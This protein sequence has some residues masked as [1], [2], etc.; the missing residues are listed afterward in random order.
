MTV[1]TLY[2]NFTDSASPPNVVFVVGAAQVHQ[3]LDADPASY[4]NMS[5]V[6]TFVVSMANTTV[7]TIDQLASLTL[8]FDVRVMSGF[9]QAPA[10][11][12]FGELRDL[13]NG[14]VYARSIWN[15]DG[16]TGFR[17]AAVKFGSVV[18]KGV[19]DRLA[20]YVFQPGGTYGERWEINDA[21]MIVDSLFDGPVATPTGPTGAINDNT[22]TLTWTTVVDDPS[23]EEEVYAR[24]RVFNVAQ[25]GAGAF[26]PATSPATWDSGARLAVPFHSITTV[27]L[28]AG[29]YRAYVSAIQRVQPGA[30]WDGRPSA[31][32]NERAPLQQGPYAFTSFSVIPVPPAVNPPTIPTDVVRDL[33]DDQRALL[34]QAT[35]P[36]PRASLY[37]PD[38]VFVR[39]LTIIEKST[40]KVTLDAQS[41][42]RGTL[43]LVV[44]DVDIVPSS[45]REATGENMPLHPF[46][47]YVHISYG[48][49]VSR[50]QPDIQVGVGVFRLTSVKRDLNAG[51]VTIK[52]KDF[53]QNLLESR[54]AYPE[55]RQDWDALPPTPFL[56]TQTVR[57]I[58][59]EAGLAYRVP[60]DDATRVVVNYAHKIGDER[61]RALDG[62]AGSLDGWTWYADIDGAIFFGPG[63]DIINDDLSYT[64]ETG[65]PDAGRFVAQVS[66]REQELTRDD[67]FDVVVAYDQAVTVVGGA[68]DANPDSVIAR[69]DADPAQ[70]TVGAGPF[71]P[72]GKPFFYS[73]PVI[74]T[75]PAAET[76]AQTRLRGVAL[77]AEAIAASCV[78][79]PDL[80]PDKMVSMARDGET[81]LVKWQVTKIV[82]P[83]TIGPT[84]TWEGVALPEDVVPAS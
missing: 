77:P 27:P 68:Y 10:D 76:A 6:G 80:R 32:L 7:M 31:V 36:V 52:G 48:I 57:L 79:I 12:I 38:G 67:V 18:P 83:L 81:A 41:Q 72:G 62:L 33:T 49:H 47:S 40:S 20:L 60:T 70:L 46:G 42:I 30:P 78:P 74:T 58:I 3:A 61:P 15:P 59:A 69:S 2:P 29:T 43:D 56:I 11:Q 13:N 45:R 9:F 55:T 35:R 65:D 82:L 23:T 16:S 21:R 14:T 24:W 22:P 53:T 84:M 44:S 37:T 34:L 8:E 73:S 28:P 50:L 5:G 4:V 25:Y 71:S 17:A 75:T 1:E 51:R 64:F 26:N 54:F 63:P 19:A 66:D 39:E